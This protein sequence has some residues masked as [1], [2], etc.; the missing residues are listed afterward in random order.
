V[1]LQAIAVAA[2]SSCLLIS[3]PLLIHD[4][5]AFAPSPVTS[6]T[7]TRGIS[8]TGSRRRH[9]SIHRL[10]H[11]RAQL[12]VLHAGSSDGSSSDTSTL[13][14]APGKSSSSSSFSES[15]FDSLSNFS[16][17]GAQ[18]ASPTT[19]AAL[20]TD[21]ERVRR[22]RQERLVELAEGEVRRA[23]RVREDALPYLGLLGLQILP[24]LGT[25]RIYS[26]TYFFGLAVATVYLGGRQETIDAPERVTRQN[27]LAAPIGASVSIGLIYVLIKAGLD[28][29]YLYALAV[30]LFGAL[31]IS[32]VGVPIL[33]N[34]LPASFAEA[35]V[36]VP[37]KVADRLDLDPP[38]LPFDG[39][40]TLALGLASTA[41][42]WSPSIGLE[43]KYL[44]SNALAWALAMT[45]LGAISLGSVQTG[46]ILLAG[47]FFYDITFVFGTD[48]MMT[49]ATKIEAPV[50]FL[51]T[52]PPS[53]TPRDYPFSVL[54]L[55]DVVIPGLFVRFMTR[56]D[57]V[58]KP[59]T[60]SYFTAT[61]AA[62]AAGL[63]VCFTV[64]EITHAGQPA[65]LYL[66]PACVGAAL[67][68]G[69]A[70]GQVEDVWNFEEEENQK[71]EKK[72]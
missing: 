10:R 63:A 13:E 11:V 19:A 29:T 34:V 36:A 32:D 40:T 58:L 47:L 65:L 26:V 12:V 20:E 37:K 27:A 8:S 41:I 67:A 53:D 61:T 64:N 50:K 57:E 25:E 43:S 51:Y 31:A 16:G 45:S 59:Q 2:T 52:A 1:R 54:G 9:C 33:R 71:E 60:L 14:T 46:V 72:V 49:V 21:D 39:L 7:T 35:E 18:S 69:V 24:L 56:L 28:P 70:N 30:S 62:Y 6:H 48:I 42:Y 5:S 68:C 44:V 55:G 17:G 4:V 15:L 38:T 3:S 66:D 22:L 23:D